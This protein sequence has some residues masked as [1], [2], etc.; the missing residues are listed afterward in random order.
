MSLRKNNGFFL[1]ELL[2]SLTA[3][4]LLC[5]ILIPLLTDLSRQSKQLE[6]EKKA[7]QLL[8]EELEE[9]LNSAPIFTNYSII[10]R[11]IEYKISWNDVP[12]PQKELCVYVDNPIA[13]TKICA[14][15]E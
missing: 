4:F 13:V 1:L 9:K 8:Y 3:W 12:S 10:Y 5:L 11:G 14:I 6:V 2:L 15:P 7:H